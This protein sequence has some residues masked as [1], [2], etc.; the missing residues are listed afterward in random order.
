MP[1]IRRFRLERTERLSPRVVGQTWSA[2]DGL[3]LRYVPGQHVCLHL[4][5]ARYFSLASAPR[6]G[7]PGGFELAVAESPGGV[8]ELPVGAEASV[9]EPAGD[10]GLRGIEAVPV[11][12]VGIGTGVA[13]L[14]AIVQGAV[15]RG[16]AA[17]LTLLCGF[18]VPENI[19]WRRE[20]RRLEAANPRFRFAPTLSRAPAAWAGRRGRVQEHV[21]ELSARTPGLHVVACGVP[22]MVRDLRAALSRAGVGADRLRAEAHG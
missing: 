1:V 6:H 16:L 11:L 13:P 17:P 10:L 19:L 7:S 18:R 4:D 12:L 5:E 22:A 8:H 3:P 14:R 21:T 2:L 15:A 20:W 9:G